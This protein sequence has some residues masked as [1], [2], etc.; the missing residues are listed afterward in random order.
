MKQAARRAMSAA[1]LVDA[2]AGS[3]LATGEAMLRETGMYPPPSVYVIDEQA[4]QPLLGHM[5]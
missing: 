5:V 1:E 2:L 4:E 3:A